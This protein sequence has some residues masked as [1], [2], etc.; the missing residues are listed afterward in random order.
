MGQNNLNQR[1]REH[2]NALRVHEKEKRDQKTRRG[3][4][5]L[6]IFSLFIF[7]AAKACIQAGELAK[8]ERQVENTPPSTMLSV[9]P[10][11]STA[12]SCETSSN[13][14]DWALLRRAERLAIADAEP[15]AGGKPVKLTEAATF[16]DYPGIVC[17]MLEF[18]AL[19]GSW[20]F[21]MKDG[22]IHGRWRDPATG[23]QMRARYCGAEP[24]TCKIVW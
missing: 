18:K 14:A 7:V 3:L 11:A 12:A 2:L 6:A 21:V 1:E 5:G 22:E 10:V 16:A 19:N 13:S 4:I 15:Y 17:G 9:T 8:L 23:G 20:S 24:R